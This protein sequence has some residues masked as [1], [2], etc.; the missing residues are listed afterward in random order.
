MKLQILE[1][2]A[3]ILHNLISYRTSLARDALPAFIRHCL[4]NIGSLGMEPTGRILFTEDSSRAENMEVLIPVSR[5]PE[6]CPQYENK[7]V[8]KLLNAVSARHE[9]D[10][11][12]MHRIEEGLRAY[13]ADRDY[14]V[15]TNPYYSIVR[16]D[17][18]RPGSA[19]ID[20]YLGINSNIL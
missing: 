10:F 13:A 11:A 20:I 17:P 5:E 7:P 19:I 16:L 9:G 3:I 1:H 4:E 8:F 2:Q 6:S 15:I 14:Q 12:D 18:D